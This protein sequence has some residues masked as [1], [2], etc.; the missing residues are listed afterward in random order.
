MPQTISFLKKVDPKLFAEAL[1]MPEGACAMMLACRWSTPLPDRF[2]D[3]GKAEIHEHTDKL[4]REFA[5]LPQAILEP[6]AQWRVEAVCRDLGLPEAEEWELLQTQETFRLAIFLA[7]LTPVQRE[8]VYELHDL[9]HSDFKRR[10]PLTESI[11]EYYVLFTQWG[12]QK[13]H[14]VLDSPWSAAEFLKT[15]GLLFVLEDGQW[16]LSRMPSWFWEELAEF[17]EGPNAYPT[18]AQMARVSVLPSSP[19]RNTRDALV[20]LADAL[21][22][23][24]MVRGMEALDTRIEA[25]FYPVRKR[26]GH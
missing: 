6:L 4:S 24:R 11:N 16:K 19:Y 17:V 8:A 18:F 14:Q 12:S 2:T 21:K 13:L 5:Q 22:D 23:D 20:F 1:K 3:T 10:P 26:L 25:E 7:E 9:E 15:F